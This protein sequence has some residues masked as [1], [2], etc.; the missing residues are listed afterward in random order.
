MILH[1]PKGES[2]S[3]GE[4]DARTTCVLRLGMTLGSNQL[5]VC[6][7]IFNLIKSFTC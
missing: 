3:E 6:A 7:P 2:W 4:G 1:L 5:D